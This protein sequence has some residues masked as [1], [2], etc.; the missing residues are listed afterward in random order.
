ML[1]N[2]SLILIVSFAVV[3]CTKTSSQLMN[4]QQNKVN[5]T[6]LPSDEDVQDNS[7]PAEQQ[8]NG[9]PV[10]APANAISCA[11]ALVAPNTTIEVNEHTVGR[12]DLGFTKHCVGRLKSGVIRTFN[13]GLSHFKKDEIVAQIKMNLV[14]KELENEKQY[15]GYSAQFFLHNENLFLPIEEPIP[16]RLNPEMP[17]PMVW[18]GL[19]NNNAD[20]YLLI[21][22]PKMECAE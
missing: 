20:K 3:G 5:S 17:T 21:C 22:E 10:V 8:G 2:L 4:D 12:P 15:S 18:E 11:I 9:A 13:T 19:I 16:F 6:P 7:I 14:Q 1:K